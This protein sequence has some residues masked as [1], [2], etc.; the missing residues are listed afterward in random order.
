VS[1]HEVLVTLFLFLTAPASAHMVARAALHLRV[2][3]VTRPPR[4]EDQ[5]AFPETAAGPVTRA[6]SDSGP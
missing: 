1:L 5:E 4:A 2:P 6:S 3:S